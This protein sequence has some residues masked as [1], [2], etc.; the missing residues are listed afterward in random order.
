L[1]GR[2]VSTA[3]GS[4]A[5]SLLSEEAS[6][7]VLV[8]TTGSAVL[9]LLSSRAEGGFCSNLDML[10]L[11]SLKLPCSWLSSRSNRL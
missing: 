7:T 11:I 2:G 8:T 4:A 10:P 1:I 5:T 9:V 6:A 3:A